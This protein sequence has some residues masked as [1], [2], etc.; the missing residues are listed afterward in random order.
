MNANLV[1]AHQK[2]TTMGSAVAQI[3]G[4]QAAKKAQLQND[5]D[6]IKITLLLWSIRWITED[7][8]R[9]PMVK[10]LV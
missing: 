6:W 8:G 7:G 1:K 2:I 5:A 10:V 3:R 9:A 4:E